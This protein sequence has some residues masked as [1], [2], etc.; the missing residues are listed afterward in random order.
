M[1]DYDKPILNKKGEPLKLLEAGAHH[2]IRCIKKTRALRKIGYETHG[3][4]DKVAY[5]TDEYKTY[6]VWQ[7]EAQFKE[8]ISI[9]ANHI[10]VDVITWD[11]EPDFPVKWIREVVGKKIP[12]ITDLHDLDSIR[13]GFIPKDERYMFNN[14]DGLIY[15]SLPI[16]EMT[17]ELHDNNKPNICLYSYC[18]EGI[19]EFDEKEIPNRRGLVYQGGANPPNDDVQNQMFAYRYLYDILKK[20][21][22]CGNEL[23]M[24]CGNM[25]AFDTYQNIGAVVHPPTMYDKMMNEL[26]QY[27]Y[28]VAIFNNEDGKKDQ[29]NY[30]LT[31][32]EFEYLQAGLPVIS[33]WTYETM[34]HIDKHKI[35][36]TFDNIDQIGDCSSFESKYP[37]IMQNIMKKRKELVME[38]FIWRLE[39]LYAK[40]LGVSKKG[41]PKNIKD[42]NVFEYGKRDVESLLK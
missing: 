7:N 14:S 29:V 34:K 26:T 10:G 22:E 40:V 20:L 18:N 1:I 11:N 13:K 25:S 16:Q 32:K 17:N 5:G 23:H 33:C 27:K 42:I 4:G 15:V 8:A 3:M 30:T 12:I 38:N 37:S 21:V 19:V 39:N 24:Y 6:M 2:C 36:F 31:N 9:Y 41:I 28:G 35:G